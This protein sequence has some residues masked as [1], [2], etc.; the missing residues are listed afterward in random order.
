MSD[1]TS[2]SPR[3]DIHV[4]GNQQKKWDLIM[5]GNKLCG[6]V[7]GGILKVGVQIFKQ[8]V[9]GS[10]VHDLFN[11]SGPR[12]SPLY[13]RETPS[14]SNFMQSMLTIHLNASLLEY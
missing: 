13:P 1:Q 6:K 8:G 12:R 14:Q 11:P 5:Q 2:D 4:V 10:N 7:L 9:Q 3:S